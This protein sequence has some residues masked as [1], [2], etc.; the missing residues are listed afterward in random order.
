LN[1]AFGL[2]LLVAQNT[3]PRLNAMVEPHI[4]SG[5]LLSGSISAMVVAVA[6]PVIVA[7]I[8]AFTIIAMIAVAVLLLSLAL[9]TTLTVAVA[10]S[11]PSIDQTTR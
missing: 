4:L 7:R 6:A 2:E 10:R 1:L 5:P 3:P 8:L 11:S 9:P